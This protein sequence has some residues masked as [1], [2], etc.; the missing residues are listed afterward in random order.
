MVAPDR[1]A[2]TVG[3]FTNAP[4]VSAAFTANN[5]KTQ[6]VIAAL[7]ARGVKPA[8]IQTSN[9]AIGA[10]DEYVL[11]ATNKKQGYNVMNNVTV[12]REDPSAVS[13]LIHSTVD[14]GAN[15]ARNLRFF[16]ADPTARAG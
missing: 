6:R 11:S 8:E 1:V 7:K 14:A 3:V 9:F 13:D 2:F 4:T 16:V 12:T 5:E 10:A 15:E